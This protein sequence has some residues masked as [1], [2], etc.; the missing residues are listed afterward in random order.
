MPRADGVVV[1]PFVVAAV[2]VT[3]RSGVDELS[4]VAWARMLL[5]LI[6]RSCW[7]CRFNGLNGAFCSCIF[8]PWSS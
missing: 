5:S 4:R 1:G 2:V 6:T 7:Y 8:G 3:G